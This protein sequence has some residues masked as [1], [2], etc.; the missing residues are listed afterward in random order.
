M[1]SIPGSG[2]YQKGLAASTNLV[3]QPVGAVTILT[4][5]EV[6]CWILSQEPA[7]ILDARHFGPFPTRNRD[8]RWPEQGAGA[9]VRVG[10]GQGWAKARQ[11]RAEVGRGGGMV[12]GRGGQ[13][14]GR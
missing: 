5:C 11:R 12:V 13:R 10:V 3:S 6:V 1:G 2:I 7:D 4:A 9:G 14:Q 8:F